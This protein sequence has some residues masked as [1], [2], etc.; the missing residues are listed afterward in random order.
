VEANRT[1]SKVVM[2]SG[3]TFDAEVLIDGQTMWSGRGYSTREEAQIAA[4]RQIKLLGPTPPPR[5]QS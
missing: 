2:V 1:S 5:R 4:D 3:G